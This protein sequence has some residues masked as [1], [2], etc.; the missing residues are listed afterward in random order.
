DKVVFGDGPKGFGEI[1]G[2]STLP[3]SNTFGFVSS[4]PCVMWLRETHEVRPDKV[5]LRDYD[6]ERPKLSVE[7]QV[8]GKD[9]GSHALEVYTF[10]GR[11]VDQAVGKRYAQ[12][13]LDSM[14]A[15]RDVLSGESS[16]LTLVPGYKFTVEGHPY[17]PLNQEYLITSVETEMREGFGSQETAGQR[18]RN[19]TCRF[20]AVPTAKTAY[21][22]P[23][24]E[25]SIP[26][27]G[28]ETAMTTGPSGGEIHTDKHGRVKI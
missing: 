6:F 4:K 22:P 18:G 1:E 24:V 20:T 5:F 19:Y 15:E 27:V 7:A 11:F 17:D 16:A 12:V 13:L 23:R 26:M 14:Q 28:F 3:F 25:R 2:E 8:E 9:K 10:P 21:R